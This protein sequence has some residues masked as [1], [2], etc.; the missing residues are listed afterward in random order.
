[1]L[2][3]F[4]A[5]MAGEIGHTLSRVAD[6][7]AQLQWGGGGNLDSLPCGE[8]QILKILRMERD[9]LQQKQQQSNG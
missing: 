1:M 3:G 9:R 4:E 5:S 8:F 7:D 2:H 6:I